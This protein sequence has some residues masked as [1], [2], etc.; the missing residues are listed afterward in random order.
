MNPAE[1]IGALI[2]DKIEEIMAI[3]DRQNRYNYDI[4]KTEVEN[5]LKN[6]ENDTDIFIDLLCSMRKRFDAL[7]AARGGHTDF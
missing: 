4:L 5:T 3:E 7:R 2:N 1:N 6:L